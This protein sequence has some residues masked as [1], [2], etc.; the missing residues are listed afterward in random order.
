MGHL[1]LKIQTSALFLKA[2]HAFSLHRK[3]SN[4]NSASPTLP[5]SPMSP[6]TPVPSNNNNYNNSSGNRNSS[7]ATSPGLHPPRNSTASGI[8]R[9]SSSTSISTGSAVTAA[10]SA[11]SSSSSSSSSTLTTGAGVIP[12]KMKRSSRFK[13]NKTFQSFR[14]RST[15]PTSTSHPT[16][17][18]SNSSVTTVTT[19][20]TTAATTATATATSRTPS[21]PTPATSPAPVYSSNPYSS[22][23]SP[24]TVAILKSPLRTR[25]SVASSKLSVSDLD[26][27]SPHYSPAPN[28]ILQPTPAV[29]FAPKY[30]MGTRLSISPTLLRHQSSEKTLTTVMQYREPIIGLQVGPFL[31]EDE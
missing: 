11:N 22:S 25:S 26:L 19:V 27:I 17:T 15:S 10:L 1:P 5:T 4:S 24:S 13:M 2:K 3:S 30:G 6:A 14:D 8:S 12:H 9:T 31:T 21:T 23:W 28:L 16:L 18:S 20:A 29:D 7:S